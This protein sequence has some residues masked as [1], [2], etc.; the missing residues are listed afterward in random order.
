LK[1]GSRVSVGAKGGVMNSIPDGEKWF[2][3]PAQPDRQAK[4]QIIAL[5]QLPDLLRR[6]AE[7][8]AKLGNQG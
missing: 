4:R 1:I 2:G 7:L 5:H 8:E 3:A 6:I